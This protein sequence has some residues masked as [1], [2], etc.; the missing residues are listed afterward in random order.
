V[1]GSVAVSDKEEGGLHVGVAAR[2]LI[3]EDLHS[4]D[5]GSFG[6]TIWPRNS[7]SSTVCSVAISILVLVSAKGLPPRGASFEGGVF[8]EDSSVCWIR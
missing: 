8:G 2:A 5:V 3:T 7:G 4:D 1:T 6:N